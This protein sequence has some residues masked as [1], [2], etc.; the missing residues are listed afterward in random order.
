MSLMIHRS[1]LTALLLAILLFLSPIFALPVSAEE[2]G[3]ELAKGALSAVVMDA[4]TGQ[5]LFAKNMHEKL[6]PASITKIM[7]ML[8]IMEALES[9]KIKWSERVRTSEHAASMGGSQ[10]FLEPGEEM[11]VHDLLKGIAVASANDATVALAEHIAGSEEEFVRLMNEK[12]KQLGLKDTH[13]MNCNGLPAAGH[14]TSAHDI[15]IMSRELLKHD[16]ILRY[17]SIYSDYLRQDSAKPFWLVNTNKLVRFFPGMD[18]LKTGFTAEAKY[19]LSATAKRGDFRVISVV[20]GEPTSTQRNAE[21]AEM[22][23]WAFSQYTSHTFFKAGQIVKTVK[24]DKGM[25]ESVPLVAADSLGIV[26]KKGER[27]KGY[28]QQMM[29]APLQAPVKKG[30]VAGS[31]VISKDGKEVARAPLVVAKDVEK[32]GFW[33]IFQRTVKHWLSFGRAA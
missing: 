4:T 22:M 28:S 32:A 33:K 18:G 21:I 30:Q 16:K 6:P 1:R 9:G 31:I 5:I 10:I 25:E 7:S 24:L 3:A 12:A 15:A 17:T 26:L 8:L 29:L 14:Y 13:F 19:C 23:N 27:L 20:M 11:S 2:S